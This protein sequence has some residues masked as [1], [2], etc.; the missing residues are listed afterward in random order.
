MAES[1]TSP[2]FR[3]SL[4]VP[5]RKK[6]V[7]RS[8]HGHGG[9]TCLET[10]P[11]ATTAFPFGVSTTEGKKS[12]VCLLSVTTTMDHVV[13]NCWD[14]SKNLSSWPKLSLSPKCCW[15]DASGWRRLFPFSWREKKKPR[16]HLDST[17]DHS[18]STL[19]TKSGRR[20]WAATESGFL[21]VWVKNTV[22]DHGHCLRANG[23]LTNVTE[24]ENGRTKIWS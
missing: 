21:V 16:N 1:K 14:I 7:T 9:T 23:L 5:K 6:F 20:R 22:V 12:L 15:W 13:Y 4:T 8:T 19:A 24:L 10:N 11:Q 18:E 2:S 17:F 3:G